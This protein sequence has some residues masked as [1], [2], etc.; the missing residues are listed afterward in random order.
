FISYTINRCPPSP[1]SA[2]QAWRK[3]II[4]RL[5]AAVGDGG[6]AVGGGEGR[7]RPRGPSYSSFVNQQPPRGK[8]KNKMIREALTSTFGINN[9]ASPRPPASCAAPE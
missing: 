9:P 8:T 3:T 5:M 6:G 2:A 4:L 7:P 1:S